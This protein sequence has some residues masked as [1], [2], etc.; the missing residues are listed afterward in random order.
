ML[1]LINAPV[2]K[3]KELITL[4]CEELAGDDEELI[5]IIKAAITPGQ[6]YT[7][8]TEERVDELLRIIKDKRIA[9][10]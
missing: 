10:K 9:R 5:A 7:E 3:I 6:N 2:D 4:L 8:M 1:M